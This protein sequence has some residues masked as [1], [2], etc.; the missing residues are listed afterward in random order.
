MQAI[1]AGS[2]ALVLVLLCGPATICLLASLCRETIRRDSARLQALMA[3]KAATPTMGGLLILAGFL[4]GT[5]FA[6]VT[7]P[8]VHGAIALSLG[9]AALGVWDDFS[10]G[11][12]D[13]RGLSPRTKLIAQ[14]IIA[15]AVVL[16]FADDGLIA[17]LTVLV[18]VGLS[19]AVN[20]T[21]GLDGLAGGCTLMVL[22]TLG[23]IA[24]LAEADSNVII[25]IASLAGAV[26][27]FLWFNRHP[28]RLFMG[29]TGSLPL[30]GLLGWFIIGMESK[31]AL[32][33]AC[34]VLLI[35]AASVVL[36]VGWFK[37]TGR[38]V[39]LCA[40]L[41]HHFQFLGWQEPRIVRSF[42]LAGFTCALMAV[43][44]FFASRPAP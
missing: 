30:G 4:A 1:A 2:I 27:G 36:Q 13:R 41:H 44:V 18:I 38:R 22:A 11:N 5:L 25:L 29:D 39:F 19:N 33:V 31:L 26:L 43:G 8:R 6:N 40:P 23:L 37:W 17:P 15:T 32:L 35:E 12:R 10:K 3:S 28:A 9:L 7:D 20:L 42:W 21:D 14:T 16:C 24:F 34:G